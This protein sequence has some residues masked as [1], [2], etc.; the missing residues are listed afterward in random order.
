[1]SAMNI[2]ILL[3]VSLVSYPALPVT[4]KVTSLP[5]QP[6]VQFKQHSGYITVN[7]S[8]HRNLFYYFV[9]AEVDPPSKP[10]VL[11]LHGVNGQYNI[12]KQIKPKFFLNIST[13]EISY[14]SHKDGALI[15]Y[16]S[17]KYGVIVKEPAP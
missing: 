1:M 17:L 16:T 5:E 8:H 10:V 3:F 11:W 9:E 6:P 12:V 7:V 4:D 15:S 2:F 14:T 13:A